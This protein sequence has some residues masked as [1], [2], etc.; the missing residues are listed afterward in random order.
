MR[1]KVTALVEAA[2]EQGKLRA[3]LD[4]LDV[5]M[6][7]LML[8]SVIE[9]TG[10]SECSDAWRRMLTIVIDGLRAGRIAPRPLTAPPLRQEELDEAMKRSGGRR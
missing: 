3:D 5:P 10:G 7:D 2:K 4:I 8:A 9:F 1:P 6:M